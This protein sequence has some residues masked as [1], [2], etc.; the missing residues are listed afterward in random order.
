MHIKLKIDPYCYPMIIIIAF[1]IGFIL[2]M[3]LRFQ[4]PYGD[5]ATQGHGQT[6]LSLVKIV[7]LADGLAL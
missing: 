2:A 5:Y 3:A 6:F 7:Q 4:L 1:I